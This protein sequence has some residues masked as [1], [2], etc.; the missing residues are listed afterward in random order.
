MV[1]ETKGPLT[2]SMQICLVSVNHC[3]LH[4]QQKFE[5]CKYPT[6]IFSFFFVVGFFFSC[7]LSFH[8]VP[9]HATHNV[10]YDGTYIQSGLFRHGGGV[11][12]WESIFNTLFFFNS[13]YA[14]FIKKNGLFHPKLRLC[15][16]KSTLKGLARLRSNLPP[17][18]PT[19]THTFLNF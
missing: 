10:Y 2:T 5:G 11:G 15:A 7:R 16:K 17:P 4:G 13:H 14:Y 12:A 1:Y 3:R 8:S 19:H 18:P 9:Q 6:H